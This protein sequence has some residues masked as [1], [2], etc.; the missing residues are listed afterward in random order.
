M[1]I[2]KRPRGCS[3]LRPKGVRV[4]QS[5]GPGARASGRNLALDAPSFTTP[6]LPAVARPHLPLS[7]T[8]SARY[9]LPTRL[10]YTMAPVSATTSLHS[11][12]T[13]HLHSCL[14]SRLSRAR[15]LFLSPRINSM[16]RVLLSLFIHTYIM[17]PRCAVEEDAFAAALRGVCPLHPQHSANLTPHFYAHQPRW[18][19]AY[20]FVQNI[21]FLLNVFW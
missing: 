18:A 10:T 1:N 2:E 14:A 17:P 19:L 4:S 7:A 3:D 20:E 16:F 15:E 5:Q 8:R 11:R 12:V 9:R 21:W 6:R 13:Q